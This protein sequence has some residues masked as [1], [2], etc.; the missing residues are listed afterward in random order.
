MG[1]GKSV[2][3]GNAR[4]ASRSPAISLF[5]RLPILGD[6]VTVSDILFVR[7]T[8]RLLNLLKPD[9]GHQRQSNE[10]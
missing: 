8:K 1:R 6:P 5:Q 9:I 3:R 2:T 4:G 10:E 7:Y